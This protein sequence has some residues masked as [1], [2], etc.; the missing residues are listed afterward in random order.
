MLI[1]AGRVVAIGET[2]KVLQTYLQT[3]TRESEVSLRNRVNRQGNGKIFFTDIYFKDENGHDVSFFRPGQNVEIWLAYEIHDSNL[4][5]FDLGI[6]FDTFLDQNRIVAVGN[7]FIGQ[8]L[9]AEVG[10]V[11]LRIKRLPLNCGRYQF[12]IIAAGSD[13]EVIDWVQ[14]AG[15]FEVVWGD[16][17]GSGQLPPPQSS[18]VLLDYS[19]VQ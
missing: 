15:E 4:K 7:K 5:E 2:E 18:A 6:S 9:K 11:K 17:Y 3:T 10:L 13:N 14:K 12:T 19:L 8:K 16:F 1:N